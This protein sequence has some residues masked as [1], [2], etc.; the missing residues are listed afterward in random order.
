MADQRQH[1]ISVLYNE[2]HTLSVYMDGNSSPVCSTKVHLSE[3]IGSKTAYLG[4]TAATGGLS[5]AHFIHSWTL[6]SVNPQPSAV[7]KQTVSSQS[8]VIPQQPKK[9]ISIQTFK[10]LPQKSKIKLSTISYPQLFTKLKELNG[11][12]ATKIDDAAI[13]NLEAFTQLLATN[14]FDVDCVTNARDA[15]LKILNG[16]QKKNIFPVLDILRMAVLHDVICPTFTTPQFINLMKQLL[17]ELSIPAIPMLCLRYFSNAIVDQSLKDVQLDQ[18]VSTLSN[19]DNLNLLKSLATLVLN[20][21][22]DVKSPAPLLKKM[23][24]LCILP[25]LFQQQDEHV[26]FPCV[27]ALGT[28]L[29]NSGDHPQ[30]LLSQLPTLW[31]SL[32]NLRN[33]KFENVKGAVNEVINFV[34]SS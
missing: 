10:Y 20:C 25:K 17:G 26:L 7:L 13:K 32:Q 33:S 19:L 6:H 5:Q 21:S 14:H 3:T 31:P 4:F 12:E 27:V 2:D 29:M 24:I 23:T 9:S 28:L 16:W 15:I 11:L 30:Q 1:F 8:P 22:F 34:E 18:A